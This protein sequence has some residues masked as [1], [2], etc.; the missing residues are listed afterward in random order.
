MPGAKPQFFRHRAAFRP[1]AILLLALSIVPVAFVGHHVASATRNVAYWDELDTAVQLVL[2]LD[3]GL[4]FSDFAGRIFAISNEHRMVTSRLIYAVSYWLT[5]TVNFAVIGFIGNA[6]IVVLCLMLL[7][8][9]GTIERRVRLGLLLAMLLFQLQHY[10]NLLWAGA[11]IDHFVVVMLAGGAVIGVAQGTR[12]ALLIGAVCALL[13]TFTLAHG[14]VTWAVGGAM[15]WQ[16]R[17]FAHLKIW[18]AVALLAIAG[19]LAGFHVNHAQRFADLSF[20][21]ALVVLRYWLAT[22][23]SVPGMG[24]NSI[25]PWLGA[26]L[27]GLLAWLI[28]RGVVRKEPVAF[29]LVCFA[30]LALALISVGRAAESNGLVHSRY[31][32]LGALAWALVLFMLLEQLSSPRLP[33]AALL[34]CAPLLVAFNVSAKRA[35][36]H[37][38]DSW[39]ECRD[40]AALRFIQHG[41][42]GK[43]P[44]WLYPTPARSTQLLNDA[45]KLGVYRLGSVCEERAFDDPEP[46][47]RITYHV[48]DVAVTSRSASVGGWAL[49]PGRPSERGQIHVVL[50]SGDTMHIFTTVAITRPDVATALKQPDCVL[51]GFGFAR[52]RD[53]LP[54]GE[55]Q[56]GFLF[57]N[58]RHTEYIMTGHRLSL[59]GEGKALLASSE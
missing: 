35:F 13:A 14:I 18:S 9:A 19:F 40:R 29:P 2:Q 34:G 57:K 45:E 46:S 8:T 32:I 20:T 12:A 22:L 10:E 28:A 52:R 11:S 31:Y 33:Y 15:L 23:G 50:R 5:G 49:I 51:S 44:F 38:A 41:V 30:I 25:S 6:S 48:E 1:V 3:A 26:V 56:L 58:G 36:A 37:K 27:L 47:S 7:Y 4:G 43:G 55:Y 21:G 53:R 54:T 39:F 24:H 42:D 16:T 17:R 59:I